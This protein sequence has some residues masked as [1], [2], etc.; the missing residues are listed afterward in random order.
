MS[1]KVAAIRP[2]IAIGAAEAL[3]ASMR[4]DLAEF[5]VEKGQEP[6][7]YVLVLIR[8]EPQSTASMQRTHP[9]ATLTR[10]A[11]RGIAIARLIQA[12]K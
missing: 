8:D 6:N 7:G 11:C 4:A 5:G 9:P 1:E 2:E 12:L 10:E 3:L